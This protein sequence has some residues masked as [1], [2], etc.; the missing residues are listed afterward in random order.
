[1]AND[2]GKGSERRSEAARKGWKTRKR[3]M[4]AL[5]AARTQAGYKAAATKGPAGRRKAAFKAAKTRKRRA[6][7]RK[8]AETKGPE[9]RRKA[10]LKA[11]ETRRQRLRDA[12]GGAEDDAKP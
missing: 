5:K 1:M 11:A 10:A 4:A 3:R 7:G 9:G 2:Y 8:S 12:K 6:A